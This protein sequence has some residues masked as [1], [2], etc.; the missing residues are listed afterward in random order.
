L[1][2]PAGTD[3]SHWFDAK[4]GDVKYYVCPD[5][6]IS[7][8]YVPS[9]DFVGI[10][11]FAPRSDYNMFGMPWWSDPKYRIGNLSKKTRLVRWKN[12]LTHQEDAV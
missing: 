6:N 5:T 9:G 10:A 12:V 4:T 11:P 8:P 2:S 1:T 3:V 7:R